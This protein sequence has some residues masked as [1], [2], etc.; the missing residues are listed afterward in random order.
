MTT[1]P[2]AN[3]SPPLDINSDGPQGR[4]EPDARR[5]MREALRRLSWHYWLVMLGGAAP[6]VIGL[7]LFLVHL[8]QQERKAAAVALEIDLVQLVDQLDHAISQADGY[9]HRTQAWAEAAL[10]EP[11]LYLNSTASGLL[12][13]IDLPA[14]DVGY[15]LDG[16]ADTSGGLLGN[17][18]LGDAFRSRPGQ[19]TE[20][21]LALGL[22]ALQRLGHE[23]YPN[24]RWSSY[25]SARRDLLTVYPFLSSSEFL[26]AAGATS[27][28]GLMD[29]VFQTPERPD[30]LEEVGP[31][32]NPDRGVVWSAP[33]ID[34]AGAGMMVS[35]F[36]PVYL[37]DDFIGATGTDV[38]LGFLSTM[39]ELSE[40][41]H[42]DLFILDAGGNLLGDNANRVANAPGVILASTVVPS[43]DLPA[44]RGDTLLHI[45]QNAEHVILTPIHSAP[46]HVLYLVPDRVLS[47]SVLAEVS[48]YVAIGL[49]MLAVLLV[50]WVLMIRYFVRPALS[51]AH[52]VSEMEGGGT[53]VSLEVPALWREW[54]AKLRETVHE[55]NDYLRRLQS[56]RAYL[57]GLIEGAPEAIVLLDADDRIVRVNQEF[58][59]LFDYTRDEALGQRLD[60]LII[61]ADRQE[62]GQF[63]ADE[64]HEGR[65][66]SREAIRQR[67]DGTPV[68]VSVLGVPISVGGGQVETYAI[69]RD[70]SEQKA[71]EEQLIQ[72]QKME[73]VGR[74]AGGIAHDFNNLL[75]A[76][77]GYVDLCR[78]TAGANSALDQ[79]LQEIRRAA[80]R[81]AELTRQLL[82]FA[83]KQIPSPQVVDVPAL[84]Q[85]LASM[86]Q[87]LIGETIQLQTLSEGSPWPVKVDTGQLEQ[88]VVNL[89]VNATDAMPD[90]G[91]LTIEVINQIL[92]QEMAQLRPGC[93]PGRYTVVKVSDTGQG[94]DAEI[95]ARIFEPFFT[96]KEQ[97]KGTGLGLATC[98]G[99]VKQADGYIDVESTPGRGSTFLVY[100][101]ATDDVPD[102]PE[103][104][105]A[106]SEPSPQSGRILVV[107]DDDL[108]RSLAER[109]LVRAR[110]EVIIA[111]DGQEAVQ[112]VLDGAVRPDL[113]LTDV[114]LPGLRGP[115]IAAHLRR[116]LPE[117]RV[118]YMSGYTDDA[119]GALNDLEGE[120]FL[121]KPFAAEALLDAVRSLFAA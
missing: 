42:G 47:A 34:A 22:F 4:L 99:I 108:V 120:F 16:L 84:V 102:S 107:E 31:E 30:P 119:G 23:A 67:K 43:V 100:L 73:A 98:Y 82:T 5:R 121:A 71:L 54:V 51:V 1:R 106:P 58:T 29:A 113:L 44:T 60:T 97:G 94:M 56:Q 66:V 77:L 39:L 11:D 10:R 12:R 3:P 80:L 8:A 110:Y 72:A 87:R 91:R 81:A 6:L 45:R 46:W 101:P 55:R 96:T 28:Q 104:E 7:T 9:A 79:D 2:S 13:P 92:D 24:L 90:G 32:N 52:F 27:M 78:I 14:G 115:E 89:V 64:V 48:G 25:Y 17:V 21:D 93:A 50:A 70:I 57:D 103:S 88:V 118:L 117:L 111:R 85:G 74:L 40:L 86:L 37:E 109:I 112:M 20:L 35:L 49:V 15:T 62:E 65:T 76:M 95:K 38:L 59:K 41:P 69:Y 26:E 18:Y 116:E 68:R 36:A 63:N 75:T 33:Y 83:R 61:S 53:P 114:V 19:G 105:E